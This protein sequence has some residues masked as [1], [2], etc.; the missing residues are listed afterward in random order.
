MAFSLLLDVGRLLRLVRC[1]A[2]FDFLLMTC[3]FG[4]GFV[5]LFVICFWCDFCWWIVYV[6]WLY[7]LFICDLHLVDWVWWL[8]CLGGGYLVVCLVWVA[9]LM[10]WLGGREWF[11]FGLLGVRLT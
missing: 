5:G 6:V 9:G 11:G 7:R 2:C 10:W 3:V 1:C 8:A 4:C